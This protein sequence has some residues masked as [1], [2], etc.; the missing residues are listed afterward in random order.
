[1]ENQDDLCTPSIGGMEQKLKPVFSV[2]EEELKDFYLKE[3]VLLAPS[4]C[5]TNRTEFEMLAIL[6]EEQKKIL[7]FLSNL[8]NYHWEQ[9]MVNMHLISVPYLLQED[10]NTKQK[11]K[12]SS[13]LTELINYLSLIVGNQHAVKQ[14]YALYGRHCA[15]VD[16]LLKQFP[17]KEKRDSGA[18]H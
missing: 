15:N 5:S 14:L 6:Q 4:Y 1:M 7:A 8:M 11:K 3:A 16:R 13:Q 17:K 2:P 12:V 18:G 9:G 10:V